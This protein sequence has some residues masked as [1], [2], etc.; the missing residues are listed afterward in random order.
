MQVQIVSDLRCRDKYVNMTWMWF[1]DQLDER[2]TRLITPWRSDYNLSL[3]NRLM[4]GAFIAEPIGF[5]MDRKMLLGIKK[6]AEAAAK[7]HEE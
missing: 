7:R 3:G 2:I 6:W 5:V 4:F 1:L